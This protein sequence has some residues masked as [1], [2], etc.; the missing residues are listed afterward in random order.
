MEKLQK[1]LTSGEL[2]SNFRKI[3]MENSVETQHGA[4]MQYNVLRNRYPD[5]YPYD[6]TRVVLKNEMHDYINAS[7]VRLSLANQSLEDKIANTDA[8]KGSSKF[9]IKFHTR[10]YKFLFYKITRIDIT[11]NFNQWVI[12]GPHGI[13]MAIDEL[14]WGLST[15]NGKNENMSH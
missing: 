10:F 15:G 6:S 12:D 2:V 4:T 7:H 13:A 1:K 9:V 11:E 3:P 8:K 14:R 5:I